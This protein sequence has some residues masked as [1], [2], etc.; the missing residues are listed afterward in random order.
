MKPRFAAYVN[1]IANDAR[2]RYG[3]VL[4]FLLY[5]VITEMLYV[6]NLR[7]DLDTY[8][9]PRVVT[10]KQA[11]DLKEY[12][13]HQ[14]AHSVTAKVNSRDR[15]ATEYWGQLSNALK[16]TEWNVEMSTGD[17]PPFTLNNGLCIHEEGQ[18][19]KPKD[20]KND[21]R[22]ILESALRQ[23]QIN[24]NCGGGSAAGDYKLFILVGHRPLAIGKEPS[25]LYRLGRWLMSFGQ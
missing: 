11:D 23:A 12:L 16:R 21:P 10:S 8:V 19:A 13:S 14:K 24:P 22:T 17:A 5:L 18:N 25:S 15:E 3:A 2:Y 20:P 7:R 4:L 1:R 9:M 6:R